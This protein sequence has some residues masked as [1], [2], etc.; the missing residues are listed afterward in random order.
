MQKNIIILLLLLIIWITGS[1]LFR[2][3]QQNTLLQERIIKLTPLDT[4][5]LGGAVTDC[6][7]LNIEYVVIGNSMTP[8]IQNGQKLRVTDNYYACNQV[9]SR[10]DIILYKSATTNGSIVKQVRALP[11]DIVKFTNKQMFINAQVLKN[12]TWAPYN[13]SE[14]ESKL[15]AAYLQDGKLQEGSFFVFGDNLTNSIDSRKIGAVGISN[16][17]GK[18]LP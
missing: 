14:N 11:G 4:V 13:F 17:R 10:N 2:S 1:F 6:K 15:L 3:K 16:F 5:K 8:L 7:T 12:S 18:V 9:V